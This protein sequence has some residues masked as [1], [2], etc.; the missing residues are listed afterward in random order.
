MDP[1]EATSEAPL[2]QAY[3]RCDAIEG[4]D[5]RAHLVVFQSVEERDEVRAAYGP[6]N[7]S[8]FADGT[9]ANDTTSTA[10]GIAVG[11]SQTGTSPA[12][13]SIDLAWGLRTV[14]ECDGAI[15]MRP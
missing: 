11:Q 10:R 15:G 5:Y 12:D 14:C 2:S 4:G 8:A 1:P 13:L 7:G 3:D 9:V 6:P